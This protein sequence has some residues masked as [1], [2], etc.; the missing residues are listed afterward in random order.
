MILRSLPRG[1]IFR[2]GESLATG[3]YPPV[4][5]TNISRLCQVKSEP[6]LRYVQSRHN[7]QSRSGDFLGVFHQKY[8]SHGDGGGAPGEFVGAVVNA[9]WASVNEVKK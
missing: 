2:R 4:E 5:Y 6:S 3:S 1:Q 8:L 7:V 9:I